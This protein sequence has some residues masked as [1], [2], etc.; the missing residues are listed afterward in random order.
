MG[1]EVATGRNLGYMSSSS[2][3]RRL[4]FIGI[5][6]E[7]QDA[8]ILAATPARLCSSGFA[9]F[10]RVAAG[11]GI[12]VGQVEVVAL[13]LVGLAVRAYATTVVAIEH[14]LAFVAETPFLRAA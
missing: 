14:R 2:I 4:P 13:R 6:V 12:V 5:S 10:A 7:E 8:A 1:Q 9:F 11:A 3:R